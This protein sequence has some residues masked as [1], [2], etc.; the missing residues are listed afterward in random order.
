MQPRQKS[1]LGYE[2]SW[3][4]WTMC[5][6]YSATPEEKNTLNTCILCSSDWLTTMWHWTEKVLH[7]TTRGRLP[8]IYPVRGRHQTSSKIS[9]N[10]E[11][12]HPAI[13]IWIETFPQNDQLF[14][15]HGPQQDVSL[16]ITPPGHQ[17]YDTIYMVAKRYCILQSI[18]ESF[19]E[20][21]LLLAFPYIDKAFNV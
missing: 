15:R 13:P 9:S 21:I 12:R 1:P 10:P 4:I 19:A 18:K 20:A 16:Q 3:Y 17:Q 6:S 14:S 5:S 8:R 11:D 7:F 2:P